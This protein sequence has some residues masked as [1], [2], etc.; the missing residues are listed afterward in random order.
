MKKELIELK[1]ELQ[2]QKSDS[3]EGYKLGVK[4]KSVQLQEMYSGMNLAYGIAINGINKIL[5]STI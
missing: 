2:R 3:L 4:E 1:E 5:K